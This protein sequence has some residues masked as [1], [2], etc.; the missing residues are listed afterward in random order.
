MS[1]SAPV[2]RKASRSNSQGGDCVELANLGRNTVGIRDSK[3]PQDGHLT[4]HPE[5][6]AHLVSRVKTGELDL[7]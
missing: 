5:V 4:V 3:A 7:I 2:W 1:K 6:L